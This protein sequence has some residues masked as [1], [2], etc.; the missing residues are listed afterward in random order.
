MAAV[1]QLVSFVADFGMTPEAAAHQPRID[2][3]GP[4][5]VTAD[6]RLAPDILRALLSRRSNG[7][8]R[9]RRAADQLRL[10]QF[11]DSS[12]AAR[13]SASA[14]PLRRGLRHWRRP[15]VSPYAGQATGPPVPAR[16]P[17]WARGGFTP[18]SASPSPHRWPR[19]FR[20][21]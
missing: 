13:A 16:L 11:A 3:S 17:D 1:L 5:K 14:M 2:V 19:A 21:W 15:A 8:C 7:D 4:D 10:P 6:A 20:H 18:G 9:A 12:R